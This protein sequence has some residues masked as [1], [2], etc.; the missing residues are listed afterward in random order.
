[1]TQKISLQKNQF[2]LNPDVIF[3][4]HGSFG[5]TP[6]PVFENY[7]AW[8]RKLEFQP[9]EF[10]G[11]ML[12]S[13]L[14]ESR[15]Q[16]GKFLNT[17]PSNLVYI[18]NST[19]GI[20]II[21]RS[22]LLHPGD[23]VLT[24]DHEY[25]AMDRT[26]KFLSKKSGFSYVT[27]N[28]QMP[29]STSET[30]ITNLFDKVTSKTK[31]IFLSHI[32]SPTSLIFPVAK[33]CEK[34]RSMGIIS[35]IDG[36][37]APGQIP[38]DL[39]DLGTDYYVGNLHK[40]LCAPKGAAF[41]YARP[42]MQKMLEP[43]VVSWGWESDCPGESTFLDYYE[44]TGTQDVSPYLAVP[45]AINFQKTNNWQGVQIGCHQLAQDILGKIS[46]RFGEPPLSTS[47]TWFAQMVGIPL[48]ARIDPLIL[49]TELYD[50]YR[51][52]VPVHKWNGR[53]ILRVSVQAYNTWAELEFL[54]ESLVK[55]I[56]D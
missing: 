51:I 49:K 50:R 52:E 39:S 56:T 31:V 40:W 15:T 18:P 17:E 6:L 42:E 44:W 54:Y 2:L 45:A 35:I 41:L 12:P 3:L 29:L 25:G 8:Q 1:M 5:A 16:L 36:A 46:S 34:A 28:L 9:V 4:N 24:T 20:N 22:L 26:W 27:A 48:P 19:H 23:E 53:T 10:L 30:F 32:T 21:A 7:Q 47:D 37:H 55:I 14:K 13:Y 33:V 38:L 43:L 11:R